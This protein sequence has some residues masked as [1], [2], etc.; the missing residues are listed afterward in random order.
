MT[1]TSIETNVSVSD[2]VEV[3]RRLWGLT[4][5]PLAL[6]SGETPPE[7]RPWSDC[8]HSAFEEL[9]A[10]LR[11][12]RVRDSVRDLLAP[13]ALQ[14]TGL[15]KALNQCSRRLLSESPEAYLATMHISGLA[16][17]LS[18]PALV[19][20]LSVAPEHPLWDTAPGP[21]PSPA[22]S[23]PGLPLVYEILSFS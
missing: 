10:A 11:P 2:S 15:E 20:T 6:L 18:D 1:R 12:A 4:G 9:V 7:L 8:A 23:R 13:P 16:A 14:K 5:A 21:A 17:T 3:A 19:R 22:A